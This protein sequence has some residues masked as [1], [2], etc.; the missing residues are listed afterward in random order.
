LKNTTIPRGLFNEVKSKKRSA[1]LLDLITKDIL[2]IL[3]KDNNA[4]K[5]IPHY[6]DDGEL[7][8]DQK[9]ATTA[10]YKEEI[11]T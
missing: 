9:E 6:I 2:N 3:V 10:S 1:D 11:L 8:S 7:P 5:E 4:V